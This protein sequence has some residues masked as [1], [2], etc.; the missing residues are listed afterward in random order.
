MTPCPIARAREGA[1]R[2]V[3]DFRPAAGINEERGKDFPT[4]FLSST[5]RR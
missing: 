2:T 4:P 3:I 1:A 5:Q